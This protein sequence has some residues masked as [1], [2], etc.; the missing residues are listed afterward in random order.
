MV[1]IVTIE[2]GRGILINVHDIEQLEPYYCPEVFVFG[3]RY[4][5][6]SDRP[7]QLCTSVKLIMS[8]TANQEHFFTRGNRLKGLQIFY[9]SET[10][11]KKKSS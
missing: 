5:T 3:D 11:Q 4:R 8:T 9:F 6:I 7:I 1:G 2:L 10:R